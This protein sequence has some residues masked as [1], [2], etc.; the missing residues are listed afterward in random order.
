MSKKKMPGILSDPWRSGVPEEPVPRM[1]ANKPVEPEQ[2]PDADF[3]ADVHT[4]IVLEGYGGIRLTTKSTTPS[5]GAILLQFCVDNLS[6]IDPILVEYGVLVD[7]LSSPVGKLPFYIQRGD[8]WCLAIPDAPSRD[9]ACLQLIQALLKMY[10]IP[11][12]QSLLVKAGIIPY[13]N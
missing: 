13:V 6:V 11:S 4:S 10:T 5:P 12:I 2:D 9:A 3:A 7:K 1:R 8:G